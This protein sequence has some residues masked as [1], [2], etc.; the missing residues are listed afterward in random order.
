[1]SGLNVD[2]SAQSPM[3]LK[4]EEAAV[5]KAVSPQLR[6]FVLS[7]GNRRLASEERR[8]WEG[9]WWWSRSVR[10]PGYEGLCE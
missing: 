3:C 4:R 6:C 9:V 5:A 1:M 2:M 10:G 7:G 8:L